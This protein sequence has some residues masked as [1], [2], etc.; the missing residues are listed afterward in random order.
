M[1]AENY[2]GARTLA[3]FEHLGT[4]FRIVR[5]RFDGKHW[6]GYLTLLCGDVPMTHDDFKQGCAATAAA[7]WKARTER[8]FPPGS[9]DAMLKAIADLNSRYGAR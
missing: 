3:S 7:E 4:T 5:R 6:R 2:T 8:T 9:K 1:N